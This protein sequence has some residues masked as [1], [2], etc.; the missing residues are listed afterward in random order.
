MLV[1][2]YTSGSFSGVPDPDAIG[3]HAE[4]CQVELGESSFPATGLFLKE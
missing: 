2:P 3:R 1:W 4:I